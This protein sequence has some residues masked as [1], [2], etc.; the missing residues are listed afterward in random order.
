STVYTVAT[1]RARLFRRDWRCHV[2]ATK[3]RSIRPSLMPHLNWIALLFS[4]SPG[5]NARH[6]DQISLIDVCILLK[7]DQSCTAVGEC[8]SM[9]RRRWPPPHAHP[10]F[11]DIAIGSITDRNDP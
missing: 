10:M 5:Q 8:Y 4:Q 11:R 9:G 7:R 6:I 2:L 3:A 1:A